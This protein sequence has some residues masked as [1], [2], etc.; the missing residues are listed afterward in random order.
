LDWLFYFF[1]DIP[2][3]EFVVINEY[4]R[5]HS[6]CNLLKVQCILNILLVKPGIL[7]IDN[8]ILCFIE[9]DDPAVFY[10]LINGFDTNQ[11]AKRFTGNTLN[12]IK[13]IVTS[14][15]TL[16]AAQRTEII[17]KLSDFGV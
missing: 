1:Q 16:P 17:K 6:A 13:E 2:E 3:D 8:L 9:S 14:K 12:T 4:M 10:R 15:H 11:L 7:F 5:K